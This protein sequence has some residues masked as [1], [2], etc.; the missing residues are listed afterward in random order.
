MQSEQLKQKIK[1]AEKLLQNEGKIVVRSSGTEPLIRVMVEAQTIEL[2]R[3]IQE[4]LC[5]F[6]N[7]LN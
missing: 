2:V 1:E 3:D 7:S 6:I 4:D 5:A